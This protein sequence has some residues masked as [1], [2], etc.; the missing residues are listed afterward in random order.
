MKYEGRIIEYSSRKRFHSI[1][2]LFVFDG[3]A[4]DYESGI[5]EES[6]HFN[7]SQEAIGHALGKLKKR[8]LSE[9][10]VG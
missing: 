2:E 5:E 1:E 10:L 7:T 9:G 3:K 8:L 4:R 6:R